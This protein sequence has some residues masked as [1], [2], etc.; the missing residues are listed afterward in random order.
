MYMAPKSQHPET[1]QKILSLFYSFFNPMLNPL[2]YSLRNA[3]VKDAHRRAR[4]KESQSQL[5]KEEKIALH[6]EGKDTHG[7][8]Q[9]SVPK[10]QQAKDKQ[11]PGAESQP[12]PLE[13]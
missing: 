4:C 5:I 11:T 10:H 13:T 8:S 2:I 7:Q 1:Q 12:G 9:I 6:P 3:E